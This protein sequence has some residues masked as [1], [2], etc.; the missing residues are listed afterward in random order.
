MEEK[1]MK[2]ETRQEVSVITKTLLMALTVL[3]VFGSSMFVRALVKGVESLS[4]QVA[5]EDVK[6]KY[7]K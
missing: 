2:T 3:A 1:N 5:T 6:F 4:Q 7:I